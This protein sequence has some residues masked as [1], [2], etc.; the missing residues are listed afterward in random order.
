MPKI[1]LRVS[2]YVGSF[3]RADG[4]GNSISKQT[5]IQ[6]SQ[7]SDEYAVMVHSLR[8]VP[9]TQQ[10]R[11]CCYSQ[12]AWNNMLR[13]RLPEGGKPIIQRDPKDYLTYAE[14]CT[15][16]RLPNKTRRE[17]YEFLC[18]ALPREIYVDGRI[19][20][21][22]SS[23]TLDT[24]AANQLRRIFRHRFIREYLYFEERQRDWCREQRIDRTDVEILER[25]FM[26]WDIPVSH[27]NKER[28]HLRRQIFRWRKEGKRMANE[29]DVIGDAEITRV[30]E[31][32]LRG[33]LP[34]YE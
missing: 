20:L 2:K 18:I 7:C 8:I 13:G 4:N 15:L 22:S 27:D 25:F 17:A 12:S 29:A 1:Y 10:R 21:V 16:E 28:E 3:M 11:A 9:E 30:D 32:E 5:P 19:E 23:H 33:G 24:S 31:Y 14:V 6:L 34:K 26:K